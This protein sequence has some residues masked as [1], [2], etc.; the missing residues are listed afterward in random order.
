MSEHRPLV[1][2]TFPMDKDGLAELFG[3]A[4]RAEPVADLPEQERSRTL[5][6][7]DVLLVWNWHKELRPAET[8]TLRARFVQLLSAGADHLPFDQLPQ[9]AVVA[10]NAGAY[11]EPI[12]EHVLA[13]TLALLKRLPQHH[14]ELAAGVWDQ[15][16]VNRSVEGAVCGILGFGG[17]G[18]AT[19]RL[20]RALGARIHA[21]NTSGR[22]D[23]PVEFVGTLDDLD[24]VLGAADVLVIALPLTRRTR[25]LIGARELRLMKPTAIL[26]NVARGAIIDQAAL[27]EHL[28][29]HPEFSAGIDAWWVEPFAA[30]EFR[31]EDPFFELPNLLGSPHNSALVPGIME[32]ATRRAAANILRF[33]RGDAVTGVVRPENY[34]EES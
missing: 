5:R 16:S 17:I 23:E 10:S 13:M 4:A 15:S 19:G 9:D 32:N 33:L 6:A 26:V 24:V 12:A 20:I 11:A 18:K 30:G 21:I 14:A 1:A 3:D 29:T 8:E 2:V 34:V 28:R 25:G 31:V 7:A 22:T 27:Y